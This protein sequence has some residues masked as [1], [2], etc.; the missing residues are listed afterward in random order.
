MTRRSPRRCPYAPLHRRGAVSVGKLEETGHLDRGLEGPVGPSRERWVGTIAEGCG[1]ARRDLFRDH[2]VDRGARTVAPRVKLVT[3]EPLIPDEQ[4]NL[5]Q[6]MPRRVREHARDGAFVP[7]HDVADDD[8][9]RQFLAR[10]DRV[11][12]R[13]EPRRTA[14]EDA[15]PRD[16]DEPGTASHALLSRYRRQPLSRMSCTWN[17]PSESTSPDGVRQTKAF[18]RASPRPKETVPRNSQVAPSGLGGTE[19]NPRMPPFGRQP[20]SDGTHSTR[21][22]PL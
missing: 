18:G 13:G 5:P 2:V 15:E 21:V 1:A 7:N 19:L 10:H 12:R 3:P 22:C 20:P 16:D 14:G 9:L 6:P 4:A 11:G 8:L 17:G